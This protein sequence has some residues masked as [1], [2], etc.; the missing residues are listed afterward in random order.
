[1]FLSRVIRKMKPVAVMILLFQASI[2]MLIPEDTEILDGFGLLSFPDTSTE[3]DYFEA[4]SL[5]SGSLYKSV[6][7]K[8]DANYGVKESDGLTSHFRPNTVSA[9]KKVPNGASQFKHPNGNAFPR[10]KSWLQNKFSPS[11]ENQEILENEEST[12]FHNSTLPIF[13]FGN[14]ILTTNRHRRSAENVEKTK[15][16]PVKDKPDRRSENLPAALKF[17]SSDFSSNRPLDNASTAPLVGKFVR[18]PFEYSKI[19]HEED[20]M[21]MDT[22]SHSMNDGMKSRTPRVNFITQQ[23][24]NIDH[25]TKVASATKSD[26]YKTPPLLHNSKE[27]SSASSSERYPDRS[28]TIRPSTFPD[29]KDYKDR[30]INSNRY[31]E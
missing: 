3:D 29:Y 26:F 8:R 24:K 5:S 2:A 17:T 16:E 21:A 27:S 25:D 13:S 9:F 22:S 10:L 18:S 14:I 30:N 12:S 20:S 6:R 7:N 4:Q 1:M 19:Q 23:K 28:S 11:Q 31:D 15:S